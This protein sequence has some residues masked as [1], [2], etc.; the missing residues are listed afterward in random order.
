L[1]GH[2]ATVSQCGGTL[3]RS[4]PRGALRRVDRLFLNFFSSCI[5]ENKFKCHFFISYFFF[6]FKV[7]HANRITHFAKWMRAGS[8]YGH[9]M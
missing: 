7:L 9:R 5:V 2:G 6:A 4:T 1:G 3:A 8:I